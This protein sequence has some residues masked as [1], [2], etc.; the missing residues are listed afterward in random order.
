MGGTE[1]ALFD[2]S[3]SLDKTEYEIRVVSLKKKGW[4]AEELE[5]KGVEV[6]SL[7]LKEGS[8]LLGLLS[9]IFLIFKVAWFLRKTKPEIIHTFLFRA[10]LIGRIGARLAGVPAVISSLRTIEEEKRYQFFFEK[11][12]SPMVDKYIAVSEKVKEHAITQLQISPDRIVTI[13]N[14]VEPKEAEGEPDPDLIKKELKITTQERVIMIIGRL[15]KEKGHI[16]LIE[17]INLVRKKIPEIKLIIIGEGEE[18][19]K[20]IKRVTQLSLSNK[21]I[22]T[23]A[24]RDVPA[25]LKIAELVVLPSLWEGMPNCLLE[26]MNAGKPVVATNVGGIP[27]VVLDGITGLLVPPANPVALGEA[28]IK[29][30]SSKDRAEAMGLMGKKRVNECFSLEK[31]IKATEAVYQ[32]ILKSKKLLC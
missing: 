25:L 10:N 19:K 32:E 15:R 27:E 6:I 9:S 18:R 4:M 23:G 31:S 3:T 24:R 26:A 13:Y 17:A 11:I 22:F 29:V 12:T 14:G 2:L 28:I 1:K 8:S 16:Y 21:V 5:K 20:L 30:L 7:G